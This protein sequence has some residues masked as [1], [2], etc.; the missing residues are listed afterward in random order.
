MTSD[1]SRPFKVWSS[2]RKTKK[3]VVAKS[4]D[5]LIQKGEFDSIPSHAVGLSVYKFACL[6]VLFLTT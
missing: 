4:L 2:D 5:E 1:V 6:Y 3:S